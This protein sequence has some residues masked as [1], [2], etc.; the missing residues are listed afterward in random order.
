MNIFYL[1]LIFIWLNN[2]YNIEII[3]NFN[4]KTSFFFYYGWFF[5]LSAQEAH[6][7]SDFSVFIN[8]YLSY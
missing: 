1:F 8:K 2:K 6:D 3:I 5:L 4:I 7:V